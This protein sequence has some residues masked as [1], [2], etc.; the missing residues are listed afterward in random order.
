MY[1]RSFTNYVDKVLV[2]FFDH[3]PTPP[4]VDIGEG[5]PLHTVILPD[6]TLEKWNLSSFTFQSFQGL[7]G[8]QNKKN[9]WI[10]ARD[11]WGTH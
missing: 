3:Q 11:S 5:I 8:T 4:P 2:F 1:N 6:W 10:P 7:I 9:F